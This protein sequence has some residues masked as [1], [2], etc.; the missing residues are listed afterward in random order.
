[1]CCLTM[2]LGAFRGRST[3]LFVTLLGTFLLRCVHSTLDNFLIALSRLL[4]FAGWGKG[5]T[6]PYCLLILY[7]AVQVLCA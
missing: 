1:M 2:M 4:S 7:A 6:H 3:E 5:Q